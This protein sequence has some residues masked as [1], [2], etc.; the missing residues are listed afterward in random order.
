[1]ALYLRSLG[2]G[3]ESIVGIC[4]RRSP[5]LI[6]SILAI[7][8]AGGAYLPLDPDYPQDRL[9]YMLE[10]SGISCVLSHSATQTASEQLFQKFSG[11]VLVWESL[12]KELVNYPTQDLALQIEDSDLSYIIYTSGST[13]KPKGVMIEHRNAVN[14]AHALHQFIALKP[15]ERVLQFASISFDAS[16]LELILA[17]TSGSALVMASKE[18]LMPG[19]ALTDTINRHQVNITLLSPT[20]LNQLNPDQLPSLDTVLSGGEA[21]PLT[22]AQKWASAKTLINAYG[23]TEITVCATMCRVDPKTDGITIG[24]PLPNYQCLILDP[25][26]NQL[27]IGISGELYIGG[28]GLARGYLNRPDLTE[29]KFVPNPFHPGTKMYRSGDLARWLPTG[30]IE[31]LAESTNRSKSA[32]S[33]SN[34]E[35]SKV[36]S[37]LRVPS[38]KLP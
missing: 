28:A 16:V 12:Q 9:Q 36:R 3:Q 31:Y 8:K 25:E 4:M 23:P 38:P 27:P 35:R 17:L 20:A 21:L 7:W 2:I 15:G 34:S 18:N 22:T 24:V 10:D 26:G 1:M 33:A 5:E 6:I 37:F 13:G 19:T 14:L 11:K 29:E 32:D 30:E